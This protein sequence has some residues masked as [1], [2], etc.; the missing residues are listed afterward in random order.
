MTRRVP[1]RRS[2]TSARRASA[3]WRRCALLLGV[4]R[5]DESGER[6]PQ[7][8]A[9]QIPQLVESVRAAGLP[10]ELELTGSPRP[11]PPAVDLSA[12]RLLQEA[13]TNVSRHAGPATVDVRVHYGDDGLDL[14]VV[15]DGI[16]SVSVSPRAGG[17]GLVAMRERVALVG[18]TL[19]V[20]PRAGGGWSVSAHL[21]AAAT[22]QTRSG[23][24]TS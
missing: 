12:Y 18:G 8:G 6:A 19:E 5:E 20:G 13:L 16:G 1:C 10:V 15:D 11:L 21:P 9:D 23:T 14:T 22:D 24:M 4:L 3:R 17:Q 2:T 7:P